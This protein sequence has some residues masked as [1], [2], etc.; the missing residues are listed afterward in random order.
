M[1][2]FA[3][4]IG[5]DHAEADLHVRLAGLLEALVTGDQFR[6]AAGDD[7]TLAEQRTTGGFTALFV[8]YRVIARKRSGVVKVFMLIDGGFLRRATGCGGQHQRQPD[9]PCGK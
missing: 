9:N 7:V 8:G 4:V 3:A 6:I 1:M 5:T 2:P